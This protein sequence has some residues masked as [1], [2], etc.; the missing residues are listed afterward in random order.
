M[1]ID[2]IVASVSSYNQASL[3]FHLKKGFGN[4]AT[5]VQAGRKFGLDV[6]MVWL[7]GSDKTGL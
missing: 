5:L 7:H 6:D 1:Q 4:V 2:S 3:K